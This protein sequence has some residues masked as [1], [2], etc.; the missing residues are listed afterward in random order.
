MQ[1]VTL[2]AAGVFCSKLCI[3]SHLDTNLIEVGQSHTQ[4]KYEQ[5]RACWLEHGSL[6]PGPTVELGSRAAVQCG[7]H[8]DQ[9]PAF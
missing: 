1:I 9:P 3:S 5:Q 2:S 4:D 8:T 6:A 7:L